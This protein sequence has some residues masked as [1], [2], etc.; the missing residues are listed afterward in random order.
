MLTMTF[1]GQDFLPKFC[2]QI[3]I[4]VRLTEE[5]TNTETQQ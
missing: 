2:E 5:L 4:S 1:K 3:E